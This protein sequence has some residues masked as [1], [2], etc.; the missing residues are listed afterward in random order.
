MK[1]QWVVVSEQEYESALI[2][3]NFWSR[4]GI[5]FSIVVT[6]LLYNVLGIQ[7]I[8]SLAPFFISVWLWYG[9]KQ[10]VDIWLSAFEEEDTEKVTD[11][12]QKLH[13]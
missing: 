4:Y 5:P 2:F 13:W 12:G 9:S 7:L 3:K 11:N 6:S 1:E 8:Y 10:I